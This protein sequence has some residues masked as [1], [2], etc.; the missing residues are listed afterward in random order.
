M[1]PFDRL[2]DVGGSTIFTFESVVFQS[3]VMIH[4]YRRRR[5]NGRGRSYPSWSRKNSSMLVIAFLCIK[6]RRRRGAS[7]HVSQVGRSV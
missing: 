2:G 3:G 6:G 1:R 5:T 4:N 7:E